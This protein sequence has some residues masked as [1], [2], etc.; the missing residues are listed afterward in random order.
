MRTV[1]STGGRPQVVNRLR[2]P[3][4]R[5]KSFSLAR[6]RVDSMSHMA[7]GRIRPIRIGAPYESKTSCEPMPT[8]RSSPNSLGQRGSAKHSLCGAA[9]D[10]G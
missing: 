6:V 5:S 8:R 2:S 1:V 4:W 9:T 7:C 3:D 10:R